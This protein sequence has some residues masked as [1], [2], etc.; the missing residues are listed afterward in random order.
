MRG[1]L[2]IAIGVAALAGASAPAQDMI[3][4]ERRRLV[5]SRAA[6]KVAEQRA[7]AFDR[8][9]RL[10]RDAA[11]KAA[12]QEIAVA[13]RVVRA[14]ADLSAARARVAII[15]TL[16]ANQ[17]ARLGDREHPVARLLAALQS[18]ARRPAVAAIAQP[19]S[20]D[21]LVRV[22]AVLGGVLPVVRARTEGLRRDM[23]ETNRLKADAALAAA[24]LRQGRVALVRE[25]RALAT[26]QARHTGRATALGRDAL[27]ESDR[28]IALGEAAR[29]SVDRMS[30]IGDDRAT[31]A[32]LQR[33][34]GPPRTDRVEGAGATAY[35]LPVV[36]RL[37]TGFG[38]ISASGVRARGLTFAVAPGTTIVAPAGG[39]IVFARPFRRY[40]TIVIVDHGAGWTT[41]VT[42]LGSTT[43]QRGG[44]VSAGEAIGLATLDETPR[45]TVELRRGE[46]PV[47]IVGL[48]G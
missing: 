8:S 26:L 48:L 7:A 42:G 36:G 31:L 5:E 44:Q 40:G 6:A 20:V 13:A 34:P 33:L 45:V 14:E 25:R 1:A 38:E 11:A 4:A 18:L 47:D 30:A 39:R 41:L 24:S 35:R 10:E 29:D 17:R 43:M 23:A 19:G 9:A 21:D 12:K 37:V 46:R 2:A 22:R 3:D 27:A 32:A 16:L 15:D 28:A